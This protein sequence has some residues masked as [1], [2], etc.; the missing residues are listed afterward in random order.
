MTIGAA[1]TQ[2]S[3]AA[4]S[5]V[6]TK[7]VKDFGHRI[8]SKL[9]SGYYNRFNE[10]DLVS[11][12]DE[13]VNSLHNFGTRDDRN[14]FEIMTKSVF[15]H[16]ITSRVE[17]QHYGK[18]ASTELGDIIFILSVVHHGRKY[19]ER[20]T[21]NQFKKDKSSILGTSWSLGNKQQLYLLSRFPTFRGA[22]P[23]LISRAQHNLSNSSGC[24]GSYGLLYRPG[25]FGFVSATQLDSFL[26]SKKSLR[27]EEMRTLKTLTSSYP[28]SHLGVYHPRTRKSFRLPQFTSPNFLWGLFGNYQFA[29]HVYDFSQKYLMMGIGELIHTSIGLGNSEALALVNAIVQT[30]GRRNPQAKEVAAQFQRFPYENGPEETTLGEGEESDNIA[31]EIGIVQTTIALGDSD[32]I[33][34]Q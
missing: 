17:F 8:E 10:V 27:M 11:A 24:L 4:N 22:K 13:V 12:V 19:F 2:F 23:S 28:E 31:G 18:P 20:A 7:Y 9:V 33:G 6:F 14:K 16:G 5:V 21:I 30:S 34:T 32:G 3:Q 26:G 25:D 1:I 29:S 15:I